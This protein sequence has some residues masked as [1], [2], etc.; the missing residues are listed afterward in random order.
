VRQVSP[1]SRLDPPRNGRQ[2]SAFATGERKEKT[3]RKR[4]K[5]FE[6]E[7]IIEENEE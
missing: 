3:R 1:R 5:N 6:N 4:R 2:E 7:S